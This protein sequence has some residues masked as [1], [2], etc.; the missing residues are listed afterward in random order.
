MARFAFLC[1]LAWALTGL[2]QFQTFSPT[3][4][5][6]LIYSIHVPDQT[7]NSSSGPIYFQMN[8][9]RSV[10]WFAL[11]Q[12]RGMRGS[13]MFVVYASGNNVTVSPRSG[14]GHSQPLYNKVANISVM[15]GSGV[16][17]GVIT[18]NVRCDSCL[19]WAGGEEDPTSTA[20]PWIWA[21][22][23]G[24]PLN[25]ANASAPIAQHDAHGFAYVNLKKGT[26]ATPAN[27]FSEL[28]RSDV[29][30]GNTGPAFDV[31]GL[32]RKK[33]AHGVLMI[34]AF[35]VF[36]PFA[37]LA[38]H[39]F[40]SSSTVT[41]HAFLQ[42]FNMAIAIAGL[43]VGVSMA[44][45]IDEIQNHHPIIGMVVVAGLAVFQPAMGL[46][47]HRHF[48]KTG[49]KGLFA[50]LHRWFGRIMFALGVINVGLGFQMT[51][52][53]RSAEQSPRGAVIAT[54]VVAGVVGVSYIVIV[55]LAGR[56]RRRRVG[57]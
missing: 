30:I 40:P 35:V 38:L 16:H 11:G 12:G 21:V 28:S 37:A 10:E 47:Q 33:I 18:A 2:A 26:G 53:G 23:Y 4:H 34:L 32:H 42:L 14:V 57:D 1:W 27:P 6:E 7:A 3:G 54:C 20:S 17:G 29:E 13:N 9:T 41:I 51:G 52:I 55:S 48:R 25:T 15:N 49:G 44:R 5:D 39:L 46:L 19:G 24:K 31:A 8:C 45:Q 22:K 50:Y 43:G 36:F 56:V